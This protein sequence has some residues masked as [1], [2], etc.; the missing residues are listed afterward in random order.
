MEN[1]WK[2]KKQQ[3]KTE[4]NRKQHKWWNKVKSKRWKTLGKNW[5]VHLLFFCIYVA[6][7]I[8]FLFAFSLY[9]FCSGKKQKTN[10]INAKKTNGTNKINA[11]T[12]QMHKSICFPLF[13]FLF[14]PLFTLLFCFCV[15]W[16]VLICFLFFSI[17][18]LVCFFQVCWF[19]WIGNGLVN[20]MQM[21]F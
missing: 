15:F 5:L 8:C 1:K 10:K 12:M 9:F 19:L 7:S 11:K 21:V 13:S 6:F 18:L 2:I 16:I 14:F 3:L 20:I 4:K 17:F